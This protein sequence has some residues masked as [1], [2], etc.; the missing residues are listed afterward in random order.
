MPDLHESLLPELENHRLPD[1]D[2]GPGIAFPHYEGRSILNLPASWSRWLGGPELHH[3]ALDIQ[4]LD[5]LAEGVEQVVVCL[6]DALGYLRLRRWLDGPARRLRPLIEQGL[7]APL[8][9]VAPSTTSAALTTIWTGRSPAEHGI[10]GYELFLREYGMIANMIQ[11][12]PATFSAGSGMLEQ[13]G[14]VPEAFLPVDPL[15]PTYRRARIEVHAFM[16][17]ALLGSGLS[18]MHLPSIEGHRYG[19]IADGWLAIRSLAESEPGARRLIW[20]YIPT[21][22]S[23]SHRFGPESI[24]VQA[25]QEQKLEALCSSCSWSP[26]RSKAARTACFCCW[27]ITDRSRRSRM[28]ITRWRAIPIW[29]GAWSWFRA[30]KTGWRIYSRVRV[31][32]RP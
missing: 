27:P 19:T 12:N 24:Q 20:M 25:D 30:G 1:L 22:D 21:L 9:S 18:R 23:L 11:H 32:S 31:R 4:A 6:I 5:A 15:G 10:L 17:Y 3:P 13:A 8:T 7:L 14:F 29:R 2:L 28:G 16:P 26:F